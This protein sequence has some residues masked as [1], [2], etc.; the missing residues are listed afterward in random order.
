[1]STAHIPLYWRKV[2]LGAIA[3]VKYG[4]AKPKEAGS[5][6][7]VGS[8]GIYGWTSDALIDFPTVVIGRKGTAGT[9]WLLEESCWPSDTTFYLDWNSKEAD[10]RFVYYCLRS[11]PLS[12]EHART[13]LPS[14]QNPDLENYILLLPPISEQR[15]IIH[16]LKSVQEAR[17]SRLRELE[18]ERERKATL[19]HRL[20]TQGVQGDLQKQTEIG[21]IPRSWDVIRLGDVAR[22]GSGGTPERNKLEYWNG[23]IPWVKT[24]E[25]NYNLITTTE[26][27]ISQEGLDNR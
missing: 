10:Y 7:A 21:E 20:F 26:E 22:V 2:R 5:V 3:A 6:P 4:K 23:G 11:R 15:A 18:L 14:L 12:G 13:T 24:G 17:D 19:M 1:M 27:T 16:V 9:A 25:I 8:G